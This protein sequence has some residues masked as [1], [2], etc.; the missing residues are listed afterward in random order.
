MR[1]GES[2]NGQDL[3]EADA[4]VERLPRGDLT[5]PEFVHHCTE[6][7]KRDI[8]PKRD[9]TV[10]RHRTTATRVER[11]AA[12]RFMANHRIGYL[13]GA[14]CCSSSHVAV[15]NCECPRPVTEGLNIF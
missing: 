7:L 12:R 5:G 2:L 8:E 11:R 13:T 4:L 3:E 14:Q 10:R 6:P 15:C 1:D 9:L